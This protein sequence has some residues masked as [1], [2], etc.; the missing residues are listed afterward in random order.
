MKRSR[1]AEEAWPDVVDAARKLYNL[2]VP[3]VGTLDARGGDPAA[4]M[5]AEKLADFCRCFSPSSNGDPAVQDLLSGKAILRDS[6]E[7]RTRYQTV[8]RESGEEL[9]MVCTARA[10]FVPQ[11]GSCGSTAADQPHTPS[12]DLLVLDLERHSALVTPVPAAL[13]G[14]RGLRDPRT[15]SLWALYAVSEAKI[16]RVWLTPAIGGTAEASGEA[17]L[18]ALRADGR[19]WSAFMGIAEQCLGEHF[20]T[21]TGPLH[22]AS[23][24][25]FEM[26]GR[27]PTMEDRIAVERLPAPQLA[28][29]AMADVQFMGLYD[30][31]GGQSCAHFAASRLHKHLAASANFRAGRVAAGLRDAF[32][33]CEASFMAE[34]ESA[35]GSCAL[36]AVL[37]GGRLHV[38]HAGDS[39]AVL[40]TGAR[41]EAVELTRDHKPDSAEERARIEAAGGA[42]VIGGRCARVTHP[43]T[44]M[45]LAT[46][47][48]LGDRDFKESWEAVA[49]SEA[50]ESAIQAHVSSESDAGAAA[51]EGE[52]DGA[53]SEER[54][55]G[56][57]ATILPLL[58][59]EPTIAEHALRDEDRFV[60]LACD[61]VWDV[62]SNQQACDSVRSSLEGSAGPEGAARKL[63]GDAFSAGSE[64]NISVLVA[65]LQQEL[66]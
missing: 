57:M 24:G 19:V 30:G 41:A 38:A 32:K 18:E 63:A 13:D 50:M 51:E 11:S 48:S 15:Q 4:G 2:P 28:R 52:R 9:R 23:V 59:A 47:R 40:C 61:G 42:V 65:V 22:S 25:I 45:M 5:V 3:R 20:S 37:G 27:R 62:L 34:G 10:V 54:A 29:P 43:G 53:A 14:S 60:I 64:D 31:H 12:C 39:R 46:S 6:T 58:S 33:E 44:S 7:L 36:V 8:F 21:L 26:R 66:V 49:T 55:A 56:P 17:A 1:T 35:S 16:R